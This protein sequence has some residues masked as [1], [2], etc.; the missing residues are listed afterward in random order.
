VNKKKNCWLT[1][2]DEIERSISRKI[3]RATVQP[4]KTCRTPKP[5]INRNPGRNYRIYEKKRMNKEKI[6]A[7]NDETTGRNDLNNRWIRAF[8]GEKRTHRLKFDFHR[9]KQNFHRLKLSFRRLKKG[10]HRLKFESH[11]LRKGFTR[12]E[13]NFH[14][15]KKDFH[16]MEFNFHRLKKNLHRLEQGF[17]RLRFKPDRMETFNHAKTILPTGGIAV[18]PLPG[19]AA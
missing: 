14:R 11:R 19:K 12:L 5:G 7:G 17:H 6:T 16:R 1:A 4:L 10:F 8:R 9:V 13:F 3:D 15:V 18:N 2:G